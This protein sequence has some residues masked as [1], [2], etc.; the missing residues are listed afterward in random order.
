MFLLS[1]EHISLFK[2]PL[3]ISPYF[4]QYSRIRHKNNTDHSL[5][6]R[7][8]LPP[9]LSIIRTGNEACGRV[10]KQ[11]F[12]Q[13]KQGA[14]IFWAVWVT[15]RCMFVSE[16]LFPLW[17]MCCLSETHTRPC[18][19]LWR[20]ATV[21]FWTQPCIHG[22][23]QDY[24]YSLSLWQK[25]PKKHELITPKLKTIQTTVSGYIRVCH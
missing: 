11:F 17:G 19:S 14:A 10:S 8:P 9:L 1:F 5:A 22:L 2:A 16:L 3:N 21:I 12:P 20:C 15:Q 7:G 13:W 6:C 25:P 24:I 18:P 4:N 23:F